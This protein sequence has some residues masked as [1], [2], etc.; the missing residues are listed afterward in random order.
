LKGLA[1]QTAG[2]PEERMRK[3]VD[4]IGLGLR[5]E[6]AEAM[7][8]RGREDIAWV[9]VHPENFIERAGGF[10]KMLADAAA[11]WPV[12]PHGLTLCFGSTEPY[13]EDY[14]RKLRGF[15]EEIRAPWYSDHLCWASADGIA[16]HD[17]L[18]LPFTR[19]SV[20]IACAR[21]AELEDA[22][23]IPVAIENI[24]YYVHLGEAEMD[25]IDFVLEVLDRSGCRLMLDVNNVYVNSRNHGFDPRAYLDR[26][27]VDRV[28]QIHVAGHLVRPGGPII[29]THGEP[30]CDEVF[31]L[32][33]HTL[34]RIG[35]PV[36]VLLERDANFP[37]WSE[38]QGELRRLRAIAA[39]ARAAEAVP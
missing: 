22:I 9:E 14:L 36:P 21:I 29:D 13:D 35:R 2:V 12:V 18:P 11:V 38:L 16:L 7:H 25:E 4:G 24:S 20:E 31:D 19:A 1:Q 34:R 6:L 8:A 15:L 17:L 23:G 39:E 32:L 30:V 26:I 28:V 37:E 10:E 27:P 33:G 3:Q 5:W